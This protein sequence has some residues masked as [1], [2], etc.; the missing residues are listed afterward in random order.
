MS[1]EKIIEV[2]NLSKFFDNKNILDKIEFTIYKGQITTLIG[3]NGAG[4]TTLASILLGLETNFT[5]NVKNFTK[6]IGYIPQKNNLKTNIPI[7]SVDM[8]SLLANKKMS[9]KQ[10][11]IKNFL[12]FTSD[13]NFHNFVQL[14]KI[15]D[16]DI[17]ELS[18]GELQKILII[19]IL[20]RDVEFFILDEPTQFLDLQ[21]QKLLYKILKD[22]SQ[23]ANKAIL[24]ISHDLFAVMRHSDQII[25][26]NQHI[27][28][29]GKIEDIHTNKDLSSALSEIG[30]YAHNHDHVH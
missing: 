24:I 4:K 13:E 23:N 14:N 6:K 21:S 2:K 29:S 7:R 26:L 9:N 18:E 1:E 15:K 8:I 10:P 5:G 22:L 28:C 16:K 25:C 30:F 3:Q 19:S 27:C 17:S 12:N 20:S 11:S